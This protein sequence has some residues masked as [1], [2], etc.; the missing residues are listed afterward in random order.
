[1]DSSG[2][3]SKTGLSEEVREELRFWVERTDDLNGQLIR[4]SPNVTRVQV[5]GSS[6]AGGHQV[7]ATMFRQEMEVAGKRCQV[8]FKEEEE[9]E[10]STFGEIRGAEEGLATLGP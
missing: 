1:M 3:R 2:W 10:S 7:G 4:K 9:M 8:G 6:D 5:V